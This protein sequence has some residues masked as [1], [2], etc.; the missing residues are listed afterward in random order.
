MIA[1]MLHRRLAP[2]VPCPRQPLIPALAA[3]KEIAPCSI[4][5]VSHDRDELNTLSGWL[6]DIYHVSTARNE[7]TAFHKI[8]TQAI[9]LIIISLELIDADGAQLCAHLKSSPDFSHIPVILLIDGG[10]P[11]IQSLQSGA[12]ASVVRPLSG[13]YLKA[14]ITNLLANRARIKEYFAHSLFAHMN[15]APS[16]KENEAF[17]DK[18]N[19]VISAHLRNMDLNVDTLA[20]LMNMSRPSFYRKM[21]CVSDLTPNELVNVARLNKAA[22][23]ISTTSHKVFEV[24]KMVGFNSQSNFGKAFFK[25]FNVTP[26]EYQ[27]ILKSQRQH[28][29]QA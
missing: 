13:D 10:F 9:H 8:E 5:L 3:Q 1:K 16:S 22:E 12:D 27:R 26:T 25:Q 17:L 15:S 29:A 11:R 18:L 6:K 28:M 14:Q 19:Q 2:L 4:L 21:K 20:R 7:R 23:L 24:V